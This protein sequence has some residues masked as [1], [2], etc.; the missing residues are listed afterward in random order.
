[1]NSDQSACI[2]T[3]A[4]YDVCACVTH[5]TDWTRAVSE[6]ACSSI[7]RLAA[8]LRERGQALAVL[9]DAELMDEA[10]TFKD[11]NPGKTATG[12]VSHELEALH[13]V[14]W[15]WQAQ[16]PPGSSAGARGARGSTALVQQV[17]HSRRPNAR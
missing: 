14:R 9:P 2:G 3:N 13:R 7:T 1:M 6:G 15:S 12:R 8:G 5:Q 4:R 10:G 16:A 17:R 11:V